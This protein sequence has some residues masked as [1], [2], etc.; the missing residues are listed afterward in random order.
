[1]KIIFRVLIIFFLILSSGIIYLSTVGIKTSKFNNQIGSVI[2]NL[3]EDL[4]IELKKVK[5]I[6]D[7]LNF[8]KTTCRM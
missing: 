5:I 8:E 2:K 3:H 4:E 6:L 1:M 7:P